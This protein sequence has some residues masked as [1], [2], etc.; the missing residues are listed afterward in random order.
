[1][2]ACIGCK[3]KKLKVPQLHLGE[4]HAAYHV[5]SAMDKHRNATIAYGL[6]E[7]GLLV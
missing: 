1:M 2:L 5:T 7:V 3:Q 4:N 6:D